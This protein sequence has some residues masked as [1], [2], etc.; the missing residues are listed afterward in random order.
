MLTRKAVVLN[1]RVYIDGGE[2]SYLDTDNVPQYQYCKVFFLSS[3][4]LKPSGFPNIQATAN[5]LLSIDLSSDWTSSTVELQSISKPERSSLTG[6]GIWKDEKNGIL[7]TGFAGYR[8]DFGDK[9]YVPQGLWSYT[10]DGSGSG[11]W[12]NLNGTADSD[13][14]N[15]PRPN[16]GQV[17]SGDGYGFFLG[18]ESGPC[19]Q[20]WRAQRN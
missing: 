3:K 19:A 16:N 1:D 6:G 14:T 11:T 4:P 12:E 8:S 2:F 7:Y 20:L 9:G 15:L 5:Q 13:F 17:A 10:S 18:G